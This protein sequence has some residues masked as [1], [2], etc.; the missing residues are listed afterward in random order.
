[1]RGVLKSTSLFLFWENRMHFAS[2]MNCSSKTVPTRVQV[3]GTR[4]EYVHV[5]SF[6]ASMRSTVTAT[7]TRVDTSALLFKRI[8][9]NYFDCRFD[10]AP[11]QLEKT[12]PC[13]A[14]V[15]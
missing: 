4:R 12:G 6:R 10:S 15:D 8:G 11:V 1:M 13:G 3:P 14:L 7:C 2:R 5:G 9:Q